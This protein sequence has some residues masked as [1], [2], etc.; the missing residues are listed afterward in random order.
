ME[1]LWQDVKYGARQLA[2]SPGFTAVA[3]LTLALGIG[4]TTAIFSFVNGVLLRPLPYPEPERVVMVCET[5]PERPAS[6]CGASPAN[7]ADWARRSRTLESIGL[8]RDWPFGIR[9]EGRIRGVSGGIATPGLFQAFRVLPVMGRVFEPRDIQPGNEHVAVVSH[10][11]WQS[12][13]GGVSDVVGKSVEID[14]QPYEIVGVLPATFRVPSLEHVEV[15]IPLWPE[16]LDWRDWRGFQAF[17]RLGPGLTL[18]Q[19][20]AELHALR[21]QMAQEFPESNAAWGLAVDSLHDR[22]VRSVRPALFMFLAAVSAVLL[23]ACANVANLFLARGSS[24]EREFAVRLALG[25]GRA[26]LVRQMLLESLLFAL[27]GGAVGIAGAYWAVDLFSTL[28]PGWFPRLD[29][30]QVD[31]AVLAFTVGVSALT[32][33]L[34]GL[35]P[36]LQAARLNLN[37]SLREGRGTESRRAGGR[38]RDILVVTEIALA[39]VLLVGAGLLL[40]SFTNLLDWKP[41]FDRNNLMMVQVFA[42]VEKY[43]Q[44][45]LA[46]LFRRCVEEVRSLPA[47]VAAGAGS[48]GPLY[49]GDGEQEF[50][51]EGR[52]IPGAGERPSVSWYDVDPDYFRTLAI[53]L[54]RGRFFT[55]ADKGGT[56]LVAIINETMARRYWPNENLIGQRVH[57]MEHKATFEIVGVVGDVRP[58]RPDE[59]PK[60]EIYWPFAQAPRWAIV[61][62]V[63]TAASSTNVIPSIRERLEGLDPDMEIGRPRTM[64]E[65]VSRQLV[66]PRF[67][68]TLAGIFAGL[69][70]AIAMV[71]IYGVMS[72]S[73]AQRTR[74]VGVRMALGAHPAGILRMVLARGLGLAAVGL[75]IG[76][77]GAFGVTRLLRSLLVDVAPTDPLT[78][79]AMAVVLLLVALVACYIPA[80]RATRVDPMVALRYE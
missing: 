46:E 11:F 31:G 58:F 71:G 26:R 15:W 32:S 77:M 20:R 35:V 48:A 27:C 28:A 68:L 66:N 65:L 37:E 29:A 19:A 14:A 16:R 55:Q 53:P 50:Y 42:P 7:W 12:S 61:L 18:P 80:R 13:L 78:F 8:A 47:V 39:C 63:R 24:R 49:G 34:F 72:F 3:V 79:A 73:V 6:W 22:T 25:A 40:R 1:T 21:N 36:A 9:Q 23:I 67:N 57:L 30:V 51:I 74:E 2:R 62:F 5:N 70:M 17:A 59:A 10:G 45:E 69:A 52:P 56:P 41:G 54:V 76:L 33:L 38:V 60:P 44:T 64:D 4:A 75:G 43:P